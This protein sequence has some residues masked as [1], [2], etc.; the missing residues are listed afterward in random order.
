MG[1]RLQNGQEKASLRLYKVFDGEDTLKPRVDR[2]ELYNVEV[3]E[4]KNGERVELRDA[5]KGIDPITYV[6]PVR[7]QRYQGLQLC[8]WTIQLR[9][10]LKEIGFTNKDVTPYWPA[11]IKNRDIKQYNRSHDEDLYAHHPKLVDEEGNE[12]EGKQ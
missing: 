4:K 12:L 3:W 7:K 9:N 10:A 2:Q 11:A 6:D 5:T 8:S 1:V